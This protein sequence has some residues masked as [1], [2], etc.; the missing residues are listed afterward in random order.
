[1]GELKSGLG[2]VCYS[3]GVLWHCYRAA[4]LLWMHGGALSFWRA[5]C[6]SSLLG[7]EVGKHPGAGRG[8]AQMPSS[9]HPLGTK[10]ILQL[11]Q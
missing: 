3:I 2:C 11:S 1:M 4:Q 7:L 6:V 8:L 10:E 5:K 9:C